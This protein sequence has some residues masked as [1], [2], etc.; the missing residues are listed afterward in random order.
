MMDENGT[1]IEVQ[2]YLDQL[3]VL[4]GDS[5]AEPVIS[6][7]LGRSARKASGTSAPPCCTAAIPAWH[8]PRSGWRPTSSSG[9]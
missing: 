9:R 2:R 5:D 6:A 4:N 1:T 8:A 3:A 7:L